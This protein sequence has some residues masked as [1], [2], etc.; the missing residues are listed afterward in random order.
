MLTIGQLSENGTRPYRMQ[1]QAT[2]AGQLWDYF[3]DVDQAAL[4][5]TIRWGRAGA[6][7]DSRTYRCEDGCAVLQIADERVDRAVAKGYVYV[8]AVQLERPEGQPPGMGGKRTVT[9][10]DCDGTE[11]TTPISGETNAYLPTVV[12]LLDTVKTGF[13]AAGQRNRIAT[14]VITGPEGT[15]TYVRRGGFVVP[16]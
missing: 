5:V 8:G 11:L 10:L 2:K 6:A 7:D 14:F 12:G 1:L 9:A 4:E 3:V 16:A 13:T 15:S